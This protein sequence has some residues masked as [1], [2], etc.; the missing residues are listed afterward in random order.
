MSKSVTSL[1]PPEAPVG[2]KQVAQKAGV[3]IATVSMSLADHP[4]VGEITKRRIRQLSQQMGYQRLRRPKGFKTARREAKKP[5]RLGFM[6]L[7]SRLEEGG[8]HGDLHDLTVCASRQG[9]RLEM[10][11][12]ADVAEIVARRA[13]LL[14]SAAAL[15]GV[16]L[17]G[18][19]DQ[20]MLNVLEQRK[21]PHVLFG[22]VWGEERAMAGPH[23]QIVMPDAAAMAQLGVE[24]LL[25][26][27]HRRIGFV[28]GRLPIGLW[29]HRWLR[30]YR[31]ALLNAGIQPQET[32]IYAGRPDQP[33]EDHAAD[34]FAGLTPAPTA[35]VIPAATAAAAFMAAMRKRGIDLSPASIIVSGTKERSLRHYGLAGCRWI[36]FDQEQ[37]AALLIHQVA[38]LFRGP[39][40]SP[41]TVLVPFALHGMG[42]SP[43]SS[44]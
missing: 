32:L 33:V 8:Q 37:V 28:C 31:N 34:V 6:L 4:G 15:D 14:D 30:G 10:L 2:L 29:N 18:Y 13:E 41:S 5:R 11:C 26:E 24:T 27:G 23:G 36:G 21:I 43:D 35:Y 40:P 7:G 9:M 22:P 17:S 25:G 44:T 42:L 38:Q 19:V 12:V 39:I 16:I 20:A 1:E 3:S